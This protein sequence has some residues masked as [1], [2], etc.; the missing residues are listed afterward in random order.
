LARS[1]VS[2][3][4]MLS[5]FGLARS[6][7]RFSPQYM[8]LKSILR[9]KVVKFNLS[10][11]LGLL[12]LKR[13]IFSSDFNIQR[14]GTWKRPRQTSVFKSANFGPAPNFLQVFFLG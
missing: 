8:I 7:Q 11:F 6:L 9:V 12:L 14:K 10:L 13:L 3:T 2:P 5:R 4:R 1:F